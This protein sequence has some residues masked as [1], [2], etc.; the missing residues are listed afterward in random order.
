M[1][2]DTE[3]SPSIQSYVIVFIALLGLL[4]LTVAAAFIDLDR[5]L[6]G[7]GWG[8]TVAWSVAF[9]KAILIA[10]Y[11]M[12]VRGAPARVITFAAAGFVWLS[13]LAALI[14]TDY[15]TR[16]PASNDARSVASARVQV[17][18]ANSK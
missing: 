5:F 1:S 3:H 6:P 4:A 15:L 7:R 14:L 2:R 13:I 11:F 16:V 17:S 12:H 9:A 10:L 18:A 8:L